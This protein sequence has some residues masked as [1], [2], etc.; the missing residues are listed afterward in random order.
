MT[1]TPAPEAPVS[2]IVG[3][4]APAAEA[5]ATGETLTRRDLLA[6]WSTVIAVVLGIL[7]VP[8]PDGISAKSWRLLA[9]FVG[10]IVGSIVRPV[11]A[12][13]MVFLGVVALAVTGTLTT[14]EALGGYA[15][16]IVWLVLCAFFISRAIVKTGLGRRIAFLFIR[17]I[18]HRSIGLSYA[19]IGSD[20]VLAS[21]IPSNGARAG[22]VVF[23]IA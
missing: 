13:A 3:A 2:R 21:V 16:P 11:P 5:H 8:V 15:D 10:T 7:L 6:R 14:A 9:I 19:L 22:G 12:G 23:P 17:A 4:A 1:A 18:G 20:A